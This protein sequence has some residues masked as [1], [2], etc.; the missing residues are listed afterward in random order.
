MGA[1]QQAGLMRADLTG[2]TLGLGKK[3][4]TRNPNPKNPN[5]N[6]NSKNP[7]YNLGS[8]FRYP[9]LF[10]KFRV[11]QTG[12]RSTRITRTSIYSVYFRNKKSS[13]PAFHTQQC[14]TPQLAAGRRCFPS[15]SSLG[16]RML[17][18]STTRMLLPATRY[19]QERS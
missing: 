17:A 12:T 13:T 5:P 4:D 11:K 16:A 6:P 19:T 1:D 15:S 14:S 18:R 9:K 8:N 10:R 3:P 2:L 7:N